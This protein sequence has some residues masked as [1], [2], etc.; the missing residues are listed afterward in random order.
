M[1]A[2]KISLPLYPVDFI[3]GF[4]THGNLQGESPG[5]ANGADACKD[6]FEVRA[7]FAQRLGFDAPVR[8]PQAIFDVDAADAIAISSELIFGNNP[9]PELFPVS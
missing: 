6:I 2:D 3:P 4:S 8:F 7:A 9:N 1:M 5:I